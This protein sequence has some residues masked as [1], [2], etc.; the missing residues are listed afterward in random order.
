[1]RRIT[2]ILSDLYLPEEAGRGASFPAALD[3]PNLDWLLRFAGRVERVGDWRA[4]LSADLGVFDLARMSVAEVCARGSMPASS[5]ST[6]WFATPVHLEA[7]IDHV[8]LA[9]RGLL[10]LGAEERE[11]WKRDFALAFGPGYAL[12]DAGERSFLLSGAAPTRAASVDPSRLLD[13]DIGQALPTGPSAGELRRLGTEIEMWLHGAPANLAREKRRHRRVSALW[14]WGGGL[15][16]NDTGVP[17]PDA[18]A[19][20]PPHAKTVVHGGDPFLSAIA[21]ASLSPA[22]ASI[23]AL[24][25]R[26]DRCIVELTPMSGSKTESLAELD[27]H[28]FAPARDALR[29]GDLTTVD[30]IANDRWFRITARSGWR[31]WR[32]RSSW[33][34][35]LA[36]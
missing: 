13:A 10:R 17:A 14:L 35:Q 27:A 18:T 3:L 20:A 25:T 12:H 7:R 29:R 31:F 5:A 28:W 15:P 6:A 8:R 36:R 26:E 9:D 2:L 23:A 16:G 11:T 22:P 19:K 24:D 21:G 34:Q 32:K 4:W 30:V 33:L 1:M